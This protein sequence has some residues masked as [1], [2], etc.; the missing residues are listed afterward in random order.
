MEPAV[1]IVDV[2][3]EALTRD[4][5]ATLGPRVKAGIGFWILV[6][7]SRSLWS[8]TRD[9]IAADYEWEIV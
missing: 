5:T 6:R 4:L 8:E 2:I 1:S 9:P 7:I 3:L